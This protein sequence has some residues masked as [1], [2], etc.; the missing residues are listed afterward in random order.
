[1]M[2]SID[3]KNCHPGYYKVVIP[4]LTRDLSGLAELRDP[5]SALQERLDRDDK[6]KI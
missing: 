1:M 5:G 2:M 3:I 6:L 4:G